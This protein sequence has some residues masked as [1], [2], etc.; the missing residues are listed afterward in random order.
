MIGV[1]VPIVRKVDDAPPGWVECQLIDAH[2]R[3]WSF[4]E[5][6]PIV[7]QT[8]LDPAT[9]YPQ[10]GVIACRVLER[11]G[12]MVRIDTDQPWGVS[13]TEGQTQ[14]DVPESLLIEW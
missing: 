7:C 4:V 14:F 9:A 8:P 11:A 13:S 10:P 12:G 3:L 5:K 1:Q 2:G 6:A